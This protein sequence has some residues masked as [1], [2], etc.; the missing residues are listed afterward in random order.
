[1]FNWGP[2]FVKRV[3]AALDGT[4]EPVEY[5]A[6][7]ADGAAELAP[8][9]Q[10]VPED[11]RQAVQEKQ[12][13]IISGE[14]EVFA[15]PL[16]DQDGNIKVPEGQVMSVTDMLSMDWFVQGVQGNPK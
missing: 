2:V 16:K 10:F 12:D 13:A 15:G 9:G 5:W 14:L 4:W 6:D 7:M 11:V 1:M 8:W 3:Q